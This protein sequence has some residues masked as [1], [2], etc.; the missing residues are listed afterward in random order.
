MKRIGF[1][2]N[3]FRSESLLV[4]TNYELIQQKKFKALEFSDSHRPDFPCC[5]RTR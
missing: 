4:I 2:M 3:S 1:E 5:S